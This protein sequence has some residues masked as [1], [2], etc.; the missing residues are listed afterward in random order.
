MHLTRTDWHDWY[1][2]DGESAVFVGDSVVVLSELATTLLDLVGDGA[3]LSEVAT[4]LAAIYGAPD[5]DATEATRLRVLE[6]V[7]RGLL[8]VDR[9]EPAA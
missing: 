7:D 9:D 5:G 4:G 8:S 2:E 3:E 1:V 6:L